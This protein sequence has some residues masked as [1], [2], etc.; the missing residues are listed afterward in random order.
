MHPV[1]F[2]TPLFIFQCA[3]ARPK[4]EPADV[5]HRT[6]PPPYM[7]MFEFVAESDYYFYLV[8]SSICPQSMILDHFG[9][10]RMTLSQGSPKAVKNVRYLLY[11]S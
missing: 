2:S 8:L 7:V 6:I 1:L 4:E 11:D 9:E 10:G 5:A 3:V